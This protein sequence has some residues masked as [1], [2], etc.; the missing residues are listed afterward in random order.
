MPKILVVVESP[1]KI[2]YISGF[3]GKD[4]VVKAS[5]GIFRDLDPKKMSIDFDNH[6]EP[7]YIIT[8]PEVVRQLKDSCKGIDMLYI[9]SDE[10]R[11]GEA[12]GQSVYQLLKPKQY[13]R[14]RFNEIT[15]KAILA[16]IKN[17]GEINYNL[18]NA[19]KARRVIDRLY[20][21]MISPLLQKKLGGMLSAG[22][23]QSVAARIV[24]DR[25]NEIIKFLEKNQDSSYFKVSGVFDNL[26]SDGPGLKASLWESTDKNP[27]TLKDTPFKGKVAHIQLPDSDPNS[28]VTSFLRTALKSTF[29]IHSVSDKIAYRNPSPP[30]TTSTLQQEAN[31]K[32]G[33]SLESTMKNAQALYEG[34]FITYMRTDSV[35]ISEEGH[36]AIKK[37]IETTY[38]SEYYQ[39]NTY[40]NKSSTSQ[41]AHEAIRP[42]HPELQSIEDKISDPFQI[43]L[44]KLIWQRTIASQ[45]KPAKLNITTIQITIS[46]F[47]SLEIKP[48]YFFQTQIE[49]MLFPGFTK[50][51]VESVDDP[52][53]DLNLNKNFKGNLPKAGDKVNMKEIVAKQEF[54][55]PQTRYTQ[56][57]LVKKLEELGIGRPSTYVNTIKTIIDREYIKIGDIPGISKTISIFSI[58]S[59][60]KKHI[61]EIFEEESKILLGREKKKLI[62]TELG[63]TVN[64]FL[65]KYFADFLDYDFTANMETDL[66]KVAEGQK[67]WTQMVKMFYDKLNP[68]VEEV[69]K[70]KSLAQQ[71]QNILG[72]DPKG[73]EIVAYKGKK[74]PVLRKKVGENFVYASIVK[75]LTLETITLEEAIKLLSYPKKLGKF[76]E[77]D[78]MLHKGEY[79]LYIKYKGQ[80][81]ALP[82]DLTDPDDITLK[83]ATK[84]IKEK[85]SK[86]LGEFNVK[87]GN[88]TVKALVLNGPYGP[89]IQANRGKK[90]MNYK[91]MPGVKPEDLTDEKVL[92]I[93]SYKKTAFK[94]GSY[95]SNSKRSGKKM[96]AKKKKEN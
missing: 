9:A 67:K 49:T 19:Q 64:D 61:M 16:A 87:E 35:E 23:V 84:A 75:P 73:N 80:C 36:K 43:K 11:E 6:F 25:E 50:V 62:P 18:V 32:F 17:P 51:Y 22:R 93:I 46:K 33:M 79:G 24:I 55:K 12:I 83:I 54:L 68:I 59:E 45:M 41:E 76:E 39:R 27:H 52:E 91:I 21:Y 15:K 89:Y 42:V 82:K 40:K 3:L 71:T 44:Y 81:V 65:I 31:R 78:V 2:S 86:T 90:K 70:T 48:F 4:Y 53:E 13:K 30:F 74:G 1:K 8:K 38:G 94:K 29:K 34:G 88:Q 7:I 56:A 72:L 58:K 28:N 47:I 96:P 77:E 60:N 95:G 69:S 57:S 85:Q 10:D 26:P 92:E 37:V 5:C 66:D 14:L 63:N 20:G